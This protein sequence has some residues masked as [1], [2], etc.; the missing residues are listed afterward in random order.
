M[1]F[2]SEAM[3]PGKQVAFMVSWLPENTGQEFEIETP[4]RRQT[5]QRSL[6]A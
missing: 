5:C 2:Y 3:K 6:P 1:G 4:D